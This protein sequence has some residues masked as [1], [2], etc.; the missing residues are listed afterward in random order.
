M[1]FRW[2]PVVQQGY[3]S[4]ISPFDSSEI[5]EEILLDVRTAKGMSGAPVFRPHN[6]EVIGIHY[7][8]IEATTAFGIPLTQGMV[9]SGL[10][11]YDKN[12]IVINE[13]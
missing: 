13:D 9:E 7:A 4:A 5:P 10:S 3:I 8:V 11:E 2:G 1:S 12:R 6:G